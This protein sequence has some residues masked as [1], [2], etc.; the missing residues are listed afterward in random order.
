M[1]KIEQAKELKEKA[2][3]ILQNKG[4]PF[5]LQ[6]LMDESFEKAAG[7]LLDNS[8][9]KKDFEDCQ[10]VKRF[11]F[12][13][14]FYELFFEKG[15]DFDTPDGGAYW[16]EFRLMFDGEEVLQ[17]QY[18]KVYPED[19]W[20]SIDY[21]IMFHEFTVKKIKLKQWVDDLPRLVKLEKIIQKND[22][23]MKAKEAE[24]KKSEEILQNFDL[25]EFQ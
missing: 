1:D 23:E 15:H 17:N 13:E 5:A 19:E 24:S 12:N 7:L 4:I 2:I 25:G 11:K 8:L 16:G 14:H 3:Q 9:T 10:K 21:E 20:S 22:K 18:Q 6:W